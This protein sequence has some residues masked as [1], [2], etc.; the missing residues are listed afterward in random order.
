MQ[1]VS[2]RNA[3][4]AAVKAVT[5]VSLAGGATL[6]RLISTPAEAQIG[7][8]FGA[9]KPPFGVALN[10]WALSD[11]TQ[12]G[13]YLAAVKRHASIAVP[14]DSMYWEVT[15]Q[16]RD[17]FDFSVADKVLSIA[18][19]NRLPFRGHVLVWHGAMPKWTEDI[20]T[21]KDAERELVHHIERTVAHYKGRI[22]SWT[23]INEMIDDTP[24]AANQGLRPSLWYRLLGERYIDIALKTIKQVDPAASLIVNDF[25]IES[26]NPNDARRR[27][28]Y[29]GLVRRLRD[30]YA[31]FSGVGIQGHVT[32]EIGIDKDGLGQFCKDVK[33]LDLDVLLTEIDVGDVKLP[34]DIEVRDAICAVRTWD[35]LEAVFAAVRPKEVYT[36]GISDRY[37]WMPMWFKRKDGLENRCLPLDKDYKPKPMMRVLEHFCRTGP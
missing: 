12:R 8:L 19:A 16:V 22:T 11:E 4:I 30:R 1:T 32:G 37:T 26:V 7:G 15:R 29:I 33:A 34:A 5:G 23:A 31:P 13:P 28:A 24:G 10:R 35:M 2:R 27:E 21:A 20:K 18:E 36:W 9:G 6:S 3:L 17:K 25:G 14:E